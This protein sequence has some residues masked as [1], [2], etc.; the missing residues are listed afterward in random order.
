MV[1][2]LQ[3]H[4]AAA[5]ADCLLAQISSVT[6]VYCLVTCQSTPSNVILHLHSV[7][8]CAMAATPAIMLQSFFIS[9]P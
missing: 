3:V 9:T 8:G 6:K 2:A 4:M 1:A 5:E 7:C